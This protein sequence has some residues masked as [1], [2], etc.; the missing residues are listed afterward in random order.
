MPL[1]ISAMIPSEGPYK[2][3]QVVFPGIFI[4]S[5]GPPDISHLFFF[6]DF[7]GLSSS[8]FWKFIV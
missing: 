5:E 8:I 1:D 4:A 2:I 7:F 6:W 3:H